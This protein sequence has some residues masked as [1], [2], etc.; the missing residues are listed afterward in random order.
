MKN[1]PV[2]VPVV[3]HQ[4][5]MGLASEDQAEHPCAVGVQRAKAPG[6][7]SPGPGRAQPLSHGRAQAGTDGQQYRQGLAGTGRSARSQSRSAGGSQGQ[8]L[9]EWLCAGPSGAHTSKL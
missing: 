1:P 5:H 7:V 6:T 8:A 4:P 2:A 9:W 3:W